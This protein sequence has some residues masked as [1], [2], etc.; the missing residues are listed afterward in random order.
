MQYG[1]DDK[2]YD[3]SDEYIKCQT[4]TVIC[5]HCMSNYVQKEANCIAVPVRKKRCFSFKSF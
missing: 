2:S 4:K 1:D 3:T 5:M